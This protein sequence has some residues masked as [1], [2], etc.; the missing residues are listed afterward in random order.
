MD[1]FSQNPEDNNEFGYSLPVR[2]ALVAS[3]MADR[4]AQSTWLIIMQDH[5]PTIV[6][7]RVLP[8]E[9]VDIVETELDERIRDLAW[10]IKKLTGRLLDRLYYEREAR[11]AVVVKMF[12]LLST[13]L[14]T[15]RDTLQDCRAPDAELAALS[16]AVER[17]I[18]LAELER[19]LLDADDFH[20]CLQE[21]QLLVAGF[22]LRCQDNW[23]G[24]VA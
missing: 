24:A 2:M 3:I 8:D 21:L 17:M 9:Q 12:A 11:H 13:L 23:G 7:V 14:D 20:A 10:P 22:V 6:S 5:A 1:R 16:L 4:P 15:W 19:D 18:W